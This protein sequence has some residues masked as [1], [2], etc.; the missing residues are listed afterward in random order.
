MRAPL[1]EPAM[2]LIDPSRLAKKRLGQL[3]PL[4]HQPLCPCPGLADELSIAPQA[5]K[6]EVGQAGLPCPE[7]LTLPAQ[8]EIDLRE[9]ESVRDL[10]ERLQT[11]LS[12]FGELLLRTGDEEAVGLFGPSPDPAA[13]LMK[14]REAEPV[15][16]L[17]DHDRRVGD[18]D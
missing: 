15:R 4:V 3:V 18:V 1:C 17:D 7:E 5:R 13:K 12:V 9:L 2:I 11:A 16:L 8:L 10:D 6:L 14:L